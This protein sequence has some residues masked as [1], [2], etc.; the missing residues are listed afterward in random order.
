MPKTGQNNTQ[1]AKQLE[2]QSRINELAS[3]LKLNNSCL[4][5]NYIQGSLSSGEYLAPEQFPN[6]TYPIK[7][8]C[9][10]CE[11]P[12][13]TDHEL[14]K[15]LVREKHKKERDKKDYV[16][17]LEANTLSLKK[18]LLQ[19]ECATIED[20]IKE[21]EECPH[22][23]VS[24]KVMIDDIVRE[25]F[26]PMAP[27]CFHEFFFHYRRWCKSMGS[28]MPD[29]KHTKK[30][31]IEFQR[32]SSYGL[33]MTDDYSGGFFHTNVHYKSLRINIKPKRIVEEYDCELDDTRKP[34][35][36]VSA[37]IGED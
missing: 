33:D 24:K 30:Y 25:V 13:K 12:L 27:M 36:I 9:A 15:H 7:F 11:T 20:F 1:S 31:M 26:R 23:Y 14:K 2:T 5:T 21:C 16:S 19:Y 22:E 17:Q 8:N 6:I 34:P 18:K 29:K 32:N 28:K 37:W 10:C 3:K 35:R 4:K